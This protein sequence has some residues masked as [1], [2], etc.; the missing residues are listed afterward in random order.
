MARTPRLNL[1]PGW[2]ARRHR[3]RR[4]SRPL[5]L[6]GHQ[7]DQLL[8]LHL[9]LRSQMELITLL[10]RKI[11]IDDALRSAPQPQQAQEASLSSGG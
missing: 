11:A 4:R 9:K 2:Q 5:H 10:A 3:P 7:P 8:N 6:G 1:T